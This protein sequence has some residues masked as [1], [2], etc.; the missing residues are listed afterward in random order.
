MHTRT[1]EYLIEHIC[2]PMYIVNSEIMRW[3]ITVLGFDLISLPVDICYTH[4]FSSWLIISN[5]YWSLKMILRNAFYYCPSV[6]PKKVK[7][8]SES[9]QML[10]RENGFHISHYHITCLLHFKNVGYC[11]ILYVLDVFASFLTKKG[12]VWKV[13]NNLYVRKRWYL[14]WRETPFYS[15]LMTINS[16]LYYFLSN[17]SYH[18]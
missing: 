2:R 16:G 10:P 18:S 1:A 12:A 4:P 14:Y 9:Q 5:F 13:F 3:Y 11:L 7:V 15:I 6:T 8:K 17:T